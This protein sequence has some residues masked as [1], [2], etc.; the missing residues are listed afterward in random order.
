[1][2]K[3][4][5]GWVV[6]EGAEL[7]MEGSIAEMFCL[8]QGAEWSFDK[9]RMSGQLCCGS[10]HD[11]GRE[12]I[13]AC[14]GTG[15]CRVGG[16]LR[17]LMADGEWAP[18]FVGVGIKKEARLALRQAQ[19]ERWSMGFGYDWAWLMARFFTPLRFVQNDTWGR[20][21]RGGRLGGMV[22]NYVGR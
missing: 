7:F 8:W 1:M 9:L 13:P 2:G 19:G 20:D 10:L 11:V 22:L 5:M 3:P 18:A 16:G 14:A 21:G 12:W 6:L 4:G 17:V 15:I